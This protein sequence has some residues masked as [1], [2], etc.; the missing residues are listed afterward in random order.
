MESTSKEIRS[1]TRARRSGG[2]CARGLQGQRHYL[3]AG[4]ETIVGILRWIMR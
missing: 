1:G 3:P 2:R 4:D